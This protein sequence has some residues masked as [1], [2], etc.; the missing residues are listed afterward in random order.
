MKVVTVQP[1]L[2]SVV[3]D[4]YTRNESFWVAVRES[5]DSQELHTINVRDGSFSNGF[6]QVLPHKFTFQGHTLIVPDRVIP[7]RG[8]T[9]VAHL[10]DGGIIVGTSEGRVTQF[11]ADGAQVWDVG[12]HLGDV[13]HLAVFPSERVVLTLGIDFHAKLWLIGELEPTRTFGQRSRW[14]GVQLL[15]KGRNFVTT[16]LSEITI[17]ECSQGTAVARF[18]QADAAL[19]VAVQIG[20]SYDARG[21]FECS[22]K[23]LLVGRQSGRISRL[24]TLGN[25]ET[26]AQG[27][28]PVTSICAT[29]NVFAGF[30][31]GEFVHLGK[32]TLR[33]QLNDC[34]VEHITPISDNVVVLSNGPD[35]LLRVTVGDSHMTHEHLCGLSETANVVAVSSN[36]NLLVA[37]KTEVALYKYIQHVYWASLQLGS[38]VNR[39]EHRLNRRR[40]HHVALHL[41]LAVHKQ[42]L[43]V[44]LTVGKL[45]KVG[46]LQD[47]LHV[48][49]GHRVN[50]GDSA[51]VFEVQKPRL[52]LALLVLEGNDNHRLDAVDGLLLD[53]LVAEPVGEL[54]EEGRGVESVGRKVRHDVEWAEAAVYIP[55]AQSHGAPSAVCTDGAWHR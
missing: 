31:N 13:T 12:A 51:G 14:T 41:Q 11:T 7:T 45:D 29:K 18:P 1:L 24:D 3:S 32:T 38:G 46:I 6:A 10:S 55:R 44:G 40:L 8:V 2:L 52:V 26:F 17:W 5:D 19:C 39:L 53:G 34:P 35:V 49:L 42:L 21:L 15:G 30:A 23:Y 28:A 50:L 20:K 54:L 9:A 33:L 4:S 16:S 22:D 48:V 27:S 36:T 43:A 47:Q 37:S 25:E